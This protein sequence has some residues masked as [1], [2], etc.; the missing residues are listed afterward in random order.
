VPEVVIP[1]RFYPR[2]YQRKVFAAREDGVRFFDLCWHRRSGKDKTLLN[3]MIREMAQTVGNYLYL[4]PTAVGARRNVWEA[5]GHDG[6]RWTDHFPPELIATKRDDQLFIRLKNGSTF[7][8]SGSDDPD[9]LRGANPI[10]VVFSEYSLC[11]ESAWDTVRPI[12]A[13]NGGWAAFCYTPKGTNHAY[14]LHQT[15]KAQQISARREWFSST[16]DVNQSL[17]D[18]VNEA[19]GAVV[20][21]DEIERDRREGVD[22]DFIQQ[23]Y[24]CSF[25]GYMVGSYYGHLMADADRQ[26][27]LT[28]VGYDARLPVETAWDLGVGDATAIWFVQRISRE[29]RLI[30]YHEDSGAS[31]TDYIK[32]VKEKPY[33]YSRHWAPHDIR[34]REFSSGRSRLESAESLGLRFDI[35]PNLPVDDGIAAVRSLLPRCYFDAD[36]CKAGINALLNYKRT[37]N[38]ERKAFEKRPYHDWSSNG[39]DAFRYLAVSEDITERPD[40]RQT[41]AETDYNPFA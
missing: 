26:G 35:V 36:R 15:A 16:L 30:D 10:G 4:L 25:S 17:R 23:E 39:A 21:L 8:L 24:Y 19:G 5:I 41:V 29:I 7:Q 3:L 9:A 33:V 12:L 28:R 40:Q 11:R 18:A 31:L 20:Q 13:E 22:E 34:V 37:F 32:V 27:R 1:H 14:K 2:S 38:E 6:L